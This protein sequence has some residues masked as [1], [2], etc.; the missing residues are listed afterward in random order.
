MSQ[1]EARPGVPR[2]ERLEST[3]QTTRIDLDAGLPEQAAA[4]YVKLQE[5]AHIRRFF[6][7]LALDQPNRR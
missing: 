1:I 3:V 5:L 4:A 2:E 6:P 7:G